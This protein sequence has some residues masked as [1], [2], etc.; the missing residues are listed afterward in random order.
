METAGD[1]DYFVIN[2]TV[3]EAVAE[4]EAIMCAEHCRPSERIEL[5]AGK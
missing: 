4:L 2:D 1:Y 5:I 3:E